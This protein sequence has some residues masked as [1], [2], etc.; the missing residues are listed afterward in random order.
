MCDI[1]FVYILVSNISRVLVSEDHQE[2]FWVKA[3]PGQ[4]RKWP[5]PH[6]PGCSIS[7]LAY[8]CFCRAGTQ[9]WVSHRPGKALT[10]ELHF[11]S[12]VVGAQV[13]RGLLFSWGRTSIQ[14]AENA[15][16]VINIWERMSASLDKTGTEMESHTLLLSIS[17][18]F[19]LYSWLS[20]RKE[21]QLV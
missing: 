16:H 8:L 18:G 14:M 19:A 4:T 20:A 6:R 9:I 1:Q 12:E 7:V 17:K 13:I 15:S 21:L 11:Q 10:P 2:S 5:E 3:R